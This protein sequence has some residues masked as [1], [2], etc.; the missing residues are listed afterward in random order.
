MN[1]VLPAGSYSG[2]S[3]SVAPSAE[4]YAA[5]AGLSDRNGSGLVAGGRCKVQI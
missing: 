4:L 3:A 5:A 2:A 1:I